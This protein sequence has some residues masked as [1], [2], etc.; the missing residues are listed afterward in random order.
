MKY[1]SL[2][3][4]LCFI[5]LPIWQAFPDEVYFS[6]QG[7]IQERIVEELGSA[8]KSI[9]IMMYSLTSD[10]LARAIV[11]AH[12]K[13]VK[14]RILLDKTQSRGNESKSDYL[15]NHDIDVRIEHQ[16][17]IMHLKVA[18]IDDSIAITGSYNWTSNAELMNQEN[19]LVID[20]PEIVQRYQERFKYLWEL[21]AED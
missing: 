19:M 15:V 13:G 8:K 16:K 14:V 4:S 2:I 3:L 12:N 5:L 17:G 18:I 10:E 7:G 6:P 20:T 1:K 11:K 9:N 21:N